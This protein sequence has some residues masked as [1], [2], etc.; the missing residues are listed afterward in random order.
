VDFRPA[1]VIILVSLTTEEDWSLSLPH[2]RALVL[3]ILIRGQRY[4]SDW[5]ALL[6]HDASVRMQLRLL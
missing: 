2:G 4:A 6:E 5:Q 1:L 3:L